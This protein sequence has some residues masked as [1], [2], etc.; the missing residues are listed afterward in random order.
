LDGV[1]VIEYLDTANGEPYVFADNKYW[2]LMK[3][4]KGS[5]FDPFIDNPKHNGIILGKAVAKLHIALKNIEDKVDI[6]DSD[7]HNEF[8]TWIVPELEKAGISFSDGVIDN[9][10]TFFERDYKSLPRQ[11]IHRD[12]HTSNLLFDDGI[13]TGYLDFDMCQT[14]VRVFDL[15]YLGCSQLVEN[16]KDTARVK[17]WREMFAGIL[18]GYNEVSP[19]CDEEVKAIPDLFIFDEV[20]FTAFYSK[21]G[22]TET[23]KSCVE[24]TNWQHENIRSILKA[25]F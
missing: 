11:L 5:V 25:M 23:A 2:C 6:Y 4:I 13:L 22:Q 10:Q 12:I 1:P 18:Q 16:Y 24:M 21:I 19:L 9:L 20:L 15:V 17:M 7:F 3:R 8:I 14:N